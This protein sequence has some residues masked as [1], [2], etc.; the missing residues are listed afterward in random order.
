MPSTFLQAVSLP[1]R[2]ADDNA[3]DL[4]LPPAAAAL[5]VS[6][7][8]A[9]QGAYGNQAVLQLLSA[10][11]MNSTGLPDEMKDG[12]ERL[13]GFALD[14]VHVHR[15]SAEPAALGA[16]ALTLGTDIHLAPGQE[17]HLPHE[18]WHVVQQKQGRVTPEVQLKDLNMNVDFA[19]ER[20][21]D[22]MGARALESR[23]PSAAETTFSRGLLGQPRTTGKQVRQFKCGCSSAPAATVYEEILDRHPVT[24]PRIIFRMDSRPLGGAT[25]PLTVGYVPRPGAVPTITEGGENQNM[26]GGA[27]NPVGSQ[28]Y[29]G[30]ARIGA[31]KETKAQWATDGVKKFYWVAAVVRSGGLTMEWLLEKIPDPDRTALRNIVLTRAQGPQAANDLLLNAI[32]DRH[33]LQGI[34][35]IGTTEIATDKIEA[36]D[37]L[38]YFEIHETGGKREALPYHVV[39]DYLAVAG[40][41][42]IP[43]EDVLRFTQFQASGGVGPQSNFM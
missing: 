19:L 17:R 37:I 12:V 32:A 39:K 7:I 20:E 13:S 6:R 16:L 9:F 30:Y 3:P 2:S 42:T 14:D 43:A 35:N 33:Q 4:A 10:S 5:D 18:A 41:A 31:S 40:A 22:T 34:K 25:G 15:N 1:R 36:D 24:V 26:V 8:T 27:L 28:N 29:L 21:A 23:F 11:R 38:G